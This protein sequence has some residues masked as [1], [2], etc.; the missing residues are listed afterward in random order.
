MGNQE[1][2]KRFSEIL[3]GEKGDRPLVSGWHHFLDKEQNA[4]DLA[5]ATIDFAKKYDW[6]LIKINPRAT[7]LP[8]IWGNRYDFEDYSWVFPKQIG[9]AIKEP[10]DVW[11]ITYKQVDESKELREQIQTVEIIREGLPDTPI[12]QTIFSPLSVLMFLTGLQPYANQSV[13]GSE[14]PLLFETL[15]K[16]NRAGVHQALHAISLTIA[17]YIKELEKSGVDGIFYAVTGTAHHDLFSEEMFNE[18]SRPYDY[19]VLNAVQEG[20]RI[21]HTCGS[22]SQPERFNDYPIEGISWDTAAEGNPGLDAKVKATKVGGIDHTIFEGSDDEKIIAQANQAIQLMNE[23]P[24][25]LVPNCAVS[26]HVKDATL[27][28]LKTFK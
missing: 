14:E 12:I 23:E 7:Y 15:F 4:E 1:K 19:I 26:P 25:I 16:E 24:F 6:D 8:E 13:Y 5:E 20:K 3:S 21:L 9:V 2:M 17:S 27:A 28:T 10:S 18:L 22:Y 11:K